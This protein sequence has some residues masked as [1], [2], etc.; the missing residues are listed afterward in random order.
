MTLSKDKIKELGDIISKEM[1]KIVSDNK[2]Y[3][4]LKRQIDTVYFMCKYNNHIQDTN[5]GICSGCYSKLI[6]K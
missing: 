6:F 1:S 2:A 3:N 4:R 5:F